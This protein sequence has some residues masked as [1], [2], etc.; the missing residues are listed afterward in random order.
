M[1]QLSG[2]TADGTGKG[3][4][5]R[6]GAEF[7]EIGDLLFAPA[8]ELP[9]GSDR[10]SS[11]EAANLVHRGAARSL[12]YPEIRFDGKVNGRSVYLTGIAGR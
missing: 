3:K 7:L 9:S 5:M 1:D 8:Q 10:G 11:R 2:G 12:A 6:S 4:P